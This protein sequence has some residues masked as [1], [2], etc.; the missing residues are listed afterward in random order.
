MALTSRIVKDKYEDGQFDHTTLT[1][2]ELAQ[3]K[4]TLVKT[5]VAYGHSRVKYPKRDIGEETLRE[6]V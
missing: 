5:L 4:E 2:E 6:D 1:L 3:V